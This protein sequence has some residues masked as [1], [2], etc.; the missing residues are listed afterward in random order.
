MFEEYGVI[1]MVCYNFVIVLWFLFEVF[2]NLI[3][4]GLIFVV[5]FFEMGIVKD[6]FIIIVVV[7]VLVY[8]VWGGL[9][10]FLCIDVV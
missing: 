4:V 7:F 3:V 2:V 1:G 9:S 10:V 8:F 5:I 6:V